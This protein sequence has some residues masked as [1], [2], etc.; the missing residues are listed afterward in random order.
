MKIAILGGRFD[1]PHIG[2]WLIALQ[3]LEIRPD[4]DQLLLVP[5][6]QHQWKPIVA[7]GEDRMQMLTFFKHPKI[8]V[9]DIELQRKGISYSIDTIKEIKHKNNA[10]IFWIVGA[11]ILPEFE[12]WE[13]KDELVEEATFLVFPRDP[14]LL[15]KNL[16]K[17]FELIHNP[18]LVT[19][20]I[21]STA[22]R[23]RVVEKKSL[24]GFVL[25]E[26]EE[27]IQK[28]GLYK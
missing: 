14:H 23:Q 7:S 2:H 25:P 12:K 22:L 24:H 27:Y 19:A 21:S 18:H 20:N 6:R 26:V 5:A 4:I 16:P 1:P 11:D 3:V 8:K 28:K 17:G 10:E 9:S 15:P 13:R